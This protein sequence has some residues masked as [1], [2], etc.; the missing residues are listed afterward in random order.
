MSLIGFG[1]RPIP[2][3]KHHMIVLDFPTLLNIVSI[4]HI[5]RL[6]PFEKNKDP[7][8]QSTSGSTSFVTKSKVGI[9]WA[10]IWI[11]H[12]FVGSNS[13]NYFIGYAPFTLTHIFPRTMS[14]M[15]FIGTQKT[16]MNIPSKGWFLGKIDLQGEFSPFKIIW[17]YNVGSTNLLLYKFALSCDRLK[18]WIPS[19]YNLVN[20]IMT[21]LFLLVL[22]KKI[23]EP[24]DYFPG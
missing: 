24:H 21:F 15:L 1:Q 5:S 6:K 10:W 20:F 4:F 14:T 7:N 3:V 2:I 13:P 22:K 23:L 8:V 12:P 18:I 16:L 17:K 9:E 11:R 19:S